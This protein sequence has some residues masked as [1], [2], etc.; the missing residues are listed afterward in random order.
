MK[1]GIYM[2]L[3]GG[4]SIVGFIIFGIIRYRSK[5]NSKKEG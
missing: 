5:I 3:F 4:L 2:T 1:E